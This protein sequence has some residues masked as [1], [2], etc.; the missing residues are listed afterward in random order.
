MMTEIVAILKFNLVC[1]LN[2]S[3]SD[4]AAFWFAIWYDIFNAFFMKI[5]IFIESI[6]MMIS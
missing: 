1:V 2:N 4:L 5:R 3:C 6:G